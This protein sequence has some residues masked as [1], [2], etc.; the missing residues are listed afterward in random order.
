VKWSR[1][2]AGPAG[3]QFLGRRKA[4]DFSLVALIL[5]GGEQGCGIG[6]GTDQG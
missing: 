3:V 2:I 6:D 1:Q 4:Q 5:P